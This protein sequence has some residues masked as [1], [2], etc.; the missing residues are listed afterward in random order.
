[1]A[2]EPERTLLARATEPTT[3]RHSA[4]PSTTVSTRRRPALF[5]AISCTEL[6]RTSASAG[7]VPGSTTDTTTIERSTEMARS[8]CPHS[9]WLWRM[10]FL[11]PTTLSTTS[12]TSARARPS[13]STTVGERAIGAHSRAPACR[14]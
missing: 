2:F 8:R 4:S 13:R 11:V 12:P 6:S 3:L 14:G 10:V 1:M 7:G 5:F 9:Q